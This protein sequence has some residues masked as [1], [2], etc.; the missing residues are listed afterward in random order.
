[1]SA[2]L[3]PI[4]SRSIA[5][6]SFIRIWYWPVKLDQVIRKTDLPVA[7]VD[8]A[9]VPFWAAAAATSVGTT[10]LDF[11]RSD[12]Y[13]NQSCTSLLLNPSLPSFVHSSWRLC[14]IQI[15]NGAITPIEKPGSSIG[16][17]P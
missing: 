5:T 2:P 10:S 16:Y 12:Q 9:G 14:R 17:I 8:A 6:V 11:R 7:I 4:G 1:M 3:A 13:W 15:S